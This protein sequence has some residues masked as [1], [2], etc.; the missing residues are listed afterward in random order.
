MFNITQII[1]KF[2]KNSSQRELDRLAPLIKKI[3]ELEPIV[4]E[5]PSEKFKIKTSELKLIFRQPRIN[6]MSPE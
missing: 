1:S 2:I 5:I 6:F 4:K 3:N